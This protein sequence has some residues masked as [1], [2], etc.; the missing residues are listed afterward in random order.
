MIEEINK[1]EVE[2]AYSLLKYE[3]H[4]ITSFQRRYCGKK[5]RKKIN[6]TV[7]KHDEH[8][9]SQVIKANINSGNLCWFV[10]WYDMMR[11]AIFFSVTFLLEAQDPSKII[12]KILDNSNWRIFHKISNR[13]SW[14]QEK[15]KKLSGKRRLRDITTKCKV[16]SWMGSW[17]RK[18][19]LGTN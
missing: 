12:R 6:S 2:T 5:K 8:Y 11:M 10:P 14:K 1:W 19:P 15:H 17:D 9:L 7:E 3:L 13:N 4:I 18:R 16:V